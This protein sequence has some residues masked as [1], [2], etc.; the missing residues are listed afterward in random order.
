[1]SVFW[2]PTRNS[3]YGLVTPAQAWRSN[4]RPLV[5]RPVVFALAWSACAPLVALNPVSSVNVPP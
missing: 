5:V 2:R 4:S 1:M 3:P